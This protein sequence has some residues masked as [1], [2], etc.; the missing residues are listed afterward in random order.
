MGLPSEAFLDGPSAI[1]KGPAGSEVV[2][3]E[4]Q[5]D[6]FSEAEAHQ[7]PLPLRYS[8]QPKERDPHLPSKLHRLC[9]RSCAQEGSRSQLSFVIDPLQPGTRR[10]TL[11]ETRFAYLTL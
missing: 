8:A 10:A 2:G 7:R 4:H 6:P 11:L 5:V 3:S 1:Q 9:F